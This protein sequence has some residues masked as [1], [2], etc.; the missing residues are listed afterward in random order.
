MASSLLDKIRALWTTNSLVLLYDLAFLNKLLLDVEVRRAIIVGISILLM[1]GSGLVYVLIYVLS[2][3]DFSL[4]AAAP[5]LVGVALFGAAT[6]QRKVNLGF[7]TGNANSRL[8]MK[9]ILVDLKQDE[10]LPA[11]V[12]RSLIAAQQY[13][14][15]GKIKDA[16][17]CTD[18]AQSIWINT[19]IRQHTNFRD[20]QKAYEKQL[21]QVMDRTKSLL[22]RR[23]QAASQ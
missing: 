8:G 5:M 9:S 23:P 22:S 20:L 6:W 19:V 21:Q 12:E 13:I 2:G 1:G 14:A 10:M 16:Q 3:H 4:Y 7:S 18:Y 11:L 17:N 15:E